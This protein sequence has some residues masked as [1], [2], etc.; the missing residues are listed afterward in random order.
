MIKYELKEKK[1]TFS[2]ETLYFAKAIRSA[3]KDT[4]MFLENV[5]RNSGRKKCQVIAVLTELAEW[6]KDCIAN[7]ESVKLDGIGRFKAELRSVGV[8][9]PKDFK[10]ANIKGVK[11]NFTPESVNGKQTLIDGLKFKKISSSPQTVI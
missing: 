10:P 3:E 2:D 8:N 6:I 5:E 1:N 7:G 9:N 11:I 4:K